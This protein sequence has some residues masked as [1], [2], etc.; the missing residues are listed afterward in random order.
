M[1]KEFSLMDKVKGNTNIVGYA[2][3]QVIEHTDDIGWDILIRME[4]LTPLGEYLEKHTMSEIEVIRLGI[5]ICRALE[6][7]ERYS[8][9]HRD[10]KLD[11]IFISEGGDYK[12]GDFG[13]ARTMDKAQQASTQVGTKQYAAPEVIQG[14]KYTSNVDTYSLGMLMYRLLNNN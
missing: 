11:N 6:V 7:C 13:I 3:H 9:I 14:R 2:D 12:L 1:T 10:I 8:I 4:L 5:D